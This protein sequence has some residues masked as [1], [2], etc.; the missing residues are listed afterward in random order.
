MKKADFVKAVN[1]AQARRDSGEETDDD[2][3]ILKHAEREGIE[4]ARSTV[5]DGEDY[6]DLTEG[7]DDA[8]EDPAYETWKA[9]DLANEVERRRGLGRQVGGTERLNK[10]QAAAALRAD[11]DDQA[12]L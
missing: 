1:D 12:S 4:P 8:P 7:E 11:D 2:R 10:A 5:D 6:I 3:R 9:A